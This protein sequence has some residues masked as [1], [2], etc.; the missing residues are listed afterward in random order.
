VGGKHLMNYYIR[1]ELICLFHAILLDITVGKRYS[2]KLYIIVCKGYY[3]NIRL[4]F[5]VI[6]IAPTA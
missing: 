1:E 2:M 5:R 3:F 4:L 6:L